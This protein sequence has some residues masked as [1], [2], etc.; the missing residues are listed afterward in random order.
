VVSAELV[1]PYADRQSEGALYFNVEFSPMASPSFEARVRPGEAATLLARL[2]E[3]SF[4]DS[5]AVDLEGLCVLAGKKVRCSIEHLQSPPTPANL[6]VLLS[7][8]PSTR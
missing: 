5:R 1:Q 3:R 2:I 8:N 4:R 7:R 6:A